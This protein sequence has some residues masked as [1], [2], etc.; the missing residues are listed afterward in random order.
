[1]KEKERLQKSE[2]EGPDDFEIIPRE[3]F[4]KGKLIRK[5]PE[6]IKVRVKQAHAEMTPGGF[7]E[8]AVG[9]LIEIAEA[10]FCD[11]LHEKIKMEE[12]DDG[13][14]TKKRRSTSPEP[15]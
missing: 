8:L 10:D 11:N 14:R 1:M 7:R 2:Y 12:K 6:K 15:V 3:S 9:A 13:T 5:E 4:H